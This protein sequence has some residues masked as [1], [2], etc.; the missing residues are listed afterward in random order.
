[1]AAPCMDET[2]ANDCAMR[3]AFVTENE[4]SP[5]QGGTERI[6]S[7]LARALMSRGHECVSVCFRPCGLPERTE[8][9][10]KYMLDA[11]R[12]L[13]R[14]ATAHPELRARLSSALSGAGAVICNLVDIRYKRLLLPLMY[15]ITRSTG[16]RLLACYHAMPGEELIG[17]PVRN[18][19]WHIRRRDRVTHYLREM[20]LSVVPRPV[21]LALRGGYIRS[22]YTLM[23]DNADKVVLL[24]RRFVPLFAHL[25]GTEDVSRLTAVPNALSFREYLPEDELAGKR[26]EILIVSRL[27]EKSKRLSR[28]LEIWSRVRHRGWKLVIVGGGPDEDYYREMAVRM[29]L[30]DMVFEGRQADLL[31]W[32]KRASVFMMTSAFE[33]WGITLTEAQQMGAVP[34]V[35]GSY[36]SVEDIIEDGVSGV[37]VPDR[38]RR[39][40]VRRLQELMRDDSK[41]VGMAR[42][43]L[44]SCRRFDIDA[45]VSQWESLLRGASR[46]DAD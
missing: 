26:K 14:R 3:I 31:P 34:I 8:F 38:R 46:P 18:C 41:R 27:D 19:L 29:H 7:T 39:R 25:A 11:T 22:R 24:S 35:Y 1:M 23:L 21:L 45:V 5:M 2:R 6:T 42:A 28:A 13:G 20:A 36:A 32:Y 43:G 37:I 33:G 30:R 10:A 44:R 16:A 15:G 9:S 40:Y 12:D 4:I 17:T